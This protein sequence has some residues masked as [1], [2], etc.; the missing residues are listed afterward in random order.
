MAEARRRQARPRQET[1]EDRIVRV[2]RAY[3]HEAEQAKKSRMQRNR[4]NLDAYFSEQD[5]S[6]KQKGQSREFLPKTASAVNQFTEFI[7]R[8]MVDFGDWFTMEIPE[9]PGVRAEDLR[10]FFRCQ[11]DSLSYGQHESLDFATLM[12]DAVKMACL[13]SLMVFKI[14]GTT[15]TTTKY[16]VERGL[17]L[18]ETP[19]GLLPQMRE[20]LVQKPVS[21]WRLQIDLVSPS[22]YY[23][24]P[25]GRML[26]EIHEVERDLTDVQALSQGD[27]P[28]YD[29]DVVAQIEV[30]YAQHHEDRRRDV[31]R[32]QDEAP[33][34][35]FRKR[36]VLSE[37][38]GGVVGEDG[39]MQEA[40]ILSTIANDKYVI[41]PPEPNP[42]WHGQSPFVSCPLI[43][44]PLSVWH[45]ALMDDG[46]QLNLSL[47]ELYNLMLDGGIS[48][49]WGNKQLRKDWLDDPRQIE[50]GIQPGMTLF[51]KEE[52]PAGA[53]VLEQVVSGQ[54]PAES[55]SLF[56]L[57]DQE[58]N[59]TSLTNDLKMGV[60]PPHDV[61]ATAIVEA[62]QSQ[63]GMID[64][65][66]RD[67]EDRGIEPVLRKA[68]LTLLQQFDQFTAQDVVQ[69]MGMQA[70]MVLARMSPAQRFVT[71][72]QGCTF[73]VNGLSAVLAR[74]RDFQKLLAL[75]QVVQANPLLLQ[76]FAQKYSVD[77]LLER[78]FKTLNIDPA[79][80][81][82]NE[83]ELAQ[84][85]PMIPAIMG[86]ALGGRGGGPAPALPSATEGAEQPSLRPQ[87]EPQMALPFGG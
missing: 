31:H 35:G 40:N 59:V 19:M 57:T 61:K 50:G 60:L 45:K 22:D 26:Y 6:Y 32:G 81:E 27:D 30:D 13:E 39:R 23:P 29:P 44:V 18:V 37:F 67:V 51:V 62:Q 16:T 75:L 21:E 41:R 42:Y 7:K 76:R 72:A 82:A 56:N 65:I 53:K 68:W 49:V 15:R 34:P 46:V 43:R 71:F 17:T 70:A 8:A 38:W 28:I 80:I 11:L 74:V 5:W 58:F 83:E 1:P 77:K 79:S 66:V 64:G 87:G 52:V 55:L 33:P 47:N 85:R 4:Q 73:K 10:R 69:T 3:K 84:T 12:A 48:A 54:V 2:V 63:A 78:L 86:I 9:I 24:D 25:T 14:H 36:V 20:D